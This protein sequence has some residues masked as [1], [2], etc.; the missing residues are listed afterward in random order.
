MQRGERKETEQ[1]LAMSLRRL[2]SSEPQWLAYGNGW[3]CN[4]PFNQYLL[5]VLYIL[6]SV[7]GIGL[8]PGI[9]NNKLFPDFSPGERIRDT[10]FFGQDLTNTVCKKQ[11]STWT[12]LTLRMEF[13]FLF[14]V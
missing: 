12:T 10:A 4:C 13:V 6:G 5:S 1:A 14:C 9:G 7:P 2:K 11:A 3:Q 8:G